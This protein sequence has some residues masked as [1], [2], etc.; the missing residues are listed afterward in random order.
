MPGV[1]AFLGCSTE[2]RM[3]IP[4]GLRRPRNTVS[5]GLRL[6]ADQRLVF[7]GAQ[8]TYGRSARLGVPSTLNDGG[9]PSCRII[10]DSSPRATPRHI[11]CP[12]AHSRAVQRV[13]VRKEDTAV[14]HPAPQFFFALRIRGTSSPNFRGSGSPARH[15]RSSLHLRPSGPARGLVSPIQCSRRRSR[16]PRSY[17][18]RGAPATASRPTRGVL[19][20]LFQERGCVPHCCASPFAPT[21]LGSFHTELRSIHSRASGPLL[22]Y[23]SGGCWSCFRGLTAIPPAR[24]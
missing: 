7:P 4:C 5:N 17:G 11:P 12:P 10:I 15:P 3:S 14:K 22:M 2:R 8:G 18:R 13:W 19:R 24:S 21:L 9:P 1:T 6:A 20:V 23:F 16:H